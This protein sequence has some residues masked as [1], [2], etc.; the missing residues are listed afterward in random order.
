M[1]ADIKKHFGVDST[2]ISGTSGVFDVVVDDQLV[3]SK[4][5]EKRFPD[6]PEVV[7]AITVLQND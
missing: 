3:F 6:N 5:S 1:A 2:L 7:A 4:H